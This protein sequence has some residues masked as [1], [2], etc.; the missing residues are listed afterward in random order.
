M[1]WSSLPD[2]W[3]YWLLFVC[4][5]VALL[6]AGLGCSTMYPRLLDDPKTIAALAKMVEESNKTWTA[7][8]ELNNPEIEFYYKVSFGG[9]VI[10]MKTELGAQGASGPQALPTAS[11]PVP[12][13]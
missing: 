11:E 10:G 6:L 3:R 7:E 8:G 2:G 9:R 4:P 12:A 5:L 1:I 13:P